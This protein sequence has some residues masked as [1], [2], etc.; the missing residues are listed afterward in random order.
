MSP[1]Q[2]T[3]ISG[4]HQN[5]NKNQQEE[6]MS[7][8][9]IVYLIVERGVEPNRQVFW[10]SAGAAFICRDGSMNLKLDIH[11]GLTFNIRDPKSNGEREEV[12]QIAGKPPVQ[13]IDDIP[14]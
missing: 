14:F 11:P 4:G 1:P 13:M 2:P 7:D 5:Q 6:I 10:R 12:N 8:F 3:G 9:K